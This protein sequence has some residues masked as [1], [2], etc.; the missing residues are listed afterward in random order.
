MP[1]VGG[2]STGFNGN[3]TKKDFE[4]FPNDLWLFYQP[5]L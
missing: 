4:T 1:Y 2:I 5:K 3:S